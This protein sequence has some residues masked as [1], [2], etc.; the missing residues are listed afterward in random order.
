MRDCHVDKNDDGGIRLSLE[1]DL[2]VYASSFSTIELPRTEVPSLLGM[3]V[4]QHSQQELRN[5]SALRGGAIAILATPSTTINAS[6]LHNRAQ[7]GG[8]GV[9]SGWATNLTSC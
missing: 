6:M 8:G 1:S 9:F 7:Q 3:R 4:C 2:A 5:N